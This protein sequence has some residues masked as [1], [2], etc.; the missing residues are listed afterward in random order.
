M[1]ESTV[2]ATALA[3]KTTGLRGAGYTYVNLDDCYIKSRDKATGKLLPDPT[4]FPSG[5]RALSDF[6]HNHS[7]KFGVYTDRGPKTCAGRPAA[8]GHEAIDAATY[9]IDWQ[10][11]YLKEDSCG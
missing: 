6:V 5:M 2:Q 11:D 8:H 7:L 3:L 9:G 1:N 10:V 4:T